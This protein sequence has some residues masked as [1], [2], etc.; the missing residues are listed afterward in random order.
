MLGVRL[1][2]QSLF[3]GRLGTCIVQG[4]SEP[5][6][7]LAVM[8]GFVLECSGDEDRPLDSDVSSFVPTDSSRA[9]YVIYIVCAMSSKTQ[10]LI[11]AN[12]GRWFRCLLHVDRASWLQSRACLCF[13]VFYTLTG[14]RGSKAEHVCTFVRV[15]VREC[16][17]ENKHGYGPHFKQAAAHMMMHIVDVCKSKAAHVVQTNA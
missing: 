1:S 8:A 7:R 13:E 3:L 5:S 6:R 10:H 15:R 16:I 11:W 4:K 2:A 12:V 14:L 17:H 9:L